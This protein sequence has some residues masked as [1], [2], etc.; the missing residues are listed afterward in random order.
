MAHP[1]ALYLNSTWIYMWMQTIR[2]FLEER[3]GSTCGRLVD[4][5]DPSTAI[6][7]GQRRIEGF[8]QI[9]LHEFPVLL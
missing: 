2:Q 5:G 3:A 4:Q 1:A 8:A 7:T 9:I 6:K